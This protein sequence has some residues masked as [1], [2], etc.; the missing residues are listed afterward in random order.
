MENSAEIDRETLDAM[1]EIRQEGTNI[2]STDESLS[3]LDVEEDEGWEDLEPDVEEVIVQSLLDNKTFPDAQSM[4]QYCLDTF[5]FDFLK[6][7]KELG[8]S[9]S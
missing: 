9:N 8:T 1:E 7:R 4:L 3:I 5:D 6:I 2:D